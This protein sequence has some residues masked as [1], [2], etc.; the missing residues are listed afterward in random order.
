MAATNKFLLLILLLACSLPGFCQNDSTNRPETTRPKSAIIPLEDLQPVPKKMTDTPA[1]E[2]VKVDSVSNLTAAKVVIINRDSLI[3]DSAR[4]AAIQ[5]TAVAVY[6]TSTYQNYETHPWLPLH[7]P[8][9]YMPIDYHTPATKDEL[10]YLIAGILFVMGFIRVTF[11][12]YFRNLFLLFFQTSLRQ[13]QTRDQLLQDG[14]ASLLSNLLFILSSALYITLLIRYKHWTE[15]PFW[16]LAAGS[17]AALLVVYLIKYLFLLFTG[18]VF[19]SK[20]AAGSYVFVVFMVNKVM[21]VLLVPFL[22]ILAFAPVNIVQA[23]ITLSIGMIALLFAYRYWV[24]FIAIRNKLKV[25]ALHFL[26]Y[27]CAVEILPLVLIY[28]V[29]IDYFTGSF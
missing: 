11:S 9:I 24:S 7:K 10:F 5:H 17:A 2:R 21:G 28:K 18:W 16:W 8:A 13:K 3:A 12:R 22:L 26:L 14:L 6:D 15:L 23:A 25:N 1:H 4:K 29:L 20:E 27:L 19:G